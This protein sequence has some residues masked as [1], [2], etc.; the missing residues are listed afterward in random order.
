MYAAKRNSITRTTHLNSRL[1]TSTKA[2]A[3]SARRGRR[4]SNERDVKAPHALHFDVL[5]AAATAAAAAAAASR[6]ARGPCCEKLR[7]V[8]RKGARIL[9][10]A[11]NRFDDCARVGGVAASS[12]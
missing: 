2:E 6:A 4:A 11:G 9:I 7:K 5:T 12:Q 3:V 8:R 10:A 1:T